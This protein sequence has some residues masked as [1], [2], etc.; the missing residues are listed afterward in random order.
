[1][2]GDTGDRRICCEALT[3]YEEIVNARSVGH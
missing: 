2:R 1:M 3:A